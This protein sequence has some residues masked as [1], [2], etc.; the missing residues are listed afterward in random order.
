MTEQKK[1]S[2]VTTLL[3][4]LARPV[5]SSGTLSGN[6]FEFREAIEK[7]LKEPSVEQAGFK[8]YMNTD[9]THR[10]A[11]A[12]A[13][14]KLFGGKVFYFALLPHSLLPIRMSPNSPPL[15]PHWSIH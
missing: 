10:A 12:I 4:K 8:F 7:V 11:P 6:L 2:G 3:S 9:E 14:Y 13:I 5:L 1:V 15:P